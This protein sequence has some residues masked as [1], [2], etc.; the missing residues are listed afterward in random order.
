M[1]V[2]L[3]TAYLLFGESW[4]PT[5][6]I[7]LG[8]LLISAL[9]IWLGNRLISKWMDR[10]FPWSS[11]G[12]WRFFTQIA[13]VLFYSLG[14][15]NLAYY[16]FKIWL[17]TTPPALEQFIVMNAYGT[18]IIIPVSSIYFGVYFLKSWNKSRLQTEIAQKETVQVQLQMLRNHLDPHFL[19]NN[20]NI[21]SALI[22]TDKAQSQKFLEKFAEVYRVIL[23]TEKEELITLSKELEFIKSYIYLIDIR[24]RD[25]IMVDIDISEDLMDHLIPPLTLQMLIENAFKHN[26]ITEDDPLQINIKSE[27][28]RVVVSNT[29]NKKDTQKS[30]NNTGLKNISL[31]YSYFTEDEVSINETPTHFIVSI[32][33][34]QIEQYESTDF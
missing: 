32:P 8:W 9:L 18:L 5:D 1:A 24:F 17:T 16:L 28:Q 27:N 26:V 20:L 11:Y 7:T 21:L 23:K 12:N 14:I 22:D 6:S 25:L 33:L 13:C 19:F 30:S 10:K 2:I 34:I 4:T 15:V 3:F 31:R 29:I